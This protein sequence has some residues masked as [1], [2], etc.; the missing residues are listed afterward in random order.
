MASYEVRLSRSARKELVAIRVKADR[1]RVVAALERLS[2]DPRPLGSVK[3][4]TSASTYRIRIGDYRVIYEV[5]DDI[6]VVDVTKVGHR[7]DVYR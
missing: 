1:T 2:S 5:L 7:R 3:L 4:T 6:L